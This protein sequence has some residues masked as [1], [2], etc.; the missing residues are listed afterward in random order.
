[1]KDRDLSTANYTSFLD[2]LTTEPNSSVSHASSLD[3]PKTEP[4]SSVSHTSSIPRLHSPA[5]KIMDLNSFMLMVPSESTSEAAK[6]SW[7]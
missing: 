5:L 3:V 2:V 7:S 4:Y 6:S 1:M